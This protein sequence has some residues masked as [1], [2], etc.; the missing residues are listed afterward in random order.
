M[1][2][3]PIDRAHAGMQ[4]APEN[5]ALRLAYYERLVDA[6]LFLLLESEAEDDAI[7]P[8]IFDTADGRFVLA[9]DREERLTAFAGGPAPYAALSGRS[10]SR[11]LAGQSMGLGLNLGVASSETLIPAEALGWL[12]ATLSERP[13]ETRDTP[14][15]LRPP[16]G[17]PDRL[18]AALDTK[19][20][21]AAG[22][23]KLA[24]LS[25]VTWKGGKRGHLLAL[26][27]PLP[28]AETAL[29]QAVGE[30]LIFS[31]MDA[32]ELDVTF[33]KAS[34]P[35]AARLAKTGLR[36][37]LPQAPKAEAPSAPGMDPEK[38][39]RLR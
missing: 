9:F 1:T 3:T 16:A 17:L 27:D 26:I 10:L 38:P 5:D 36:F 19:L 33:L 12:N 31:G 2:E 39:P 35:V 28:G 6:E 34:D 37:D 15:E 13:R 20:A 8:R 14:E 4:A 25:A 24:Y 29:A 23:A 32:G 22:L 30:A 18:V 11:M 7:A 21:T